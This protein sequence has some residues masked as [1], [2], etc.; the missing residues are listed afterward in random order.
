M[1][2]CG[3]SHLRAFDSDLRFKQALAP[4]TGAPGWFDELVFTEEKAARAAAGGFD[5]DAL[6][7]GARRA[8]GVAEV[9]LDVAA[10]HP[11]LTRER[12]D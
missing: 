12:R 11:Q 5:Q 2:F 3:L 6:A 4:T 7:G 10:R 1:F 8:D 9:V